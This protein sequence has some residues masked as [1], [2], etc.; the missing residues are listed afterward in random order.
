L[1]VLGISA[2]ALGMSFDDWQPAVNVGSLPGTDPTFNTASLDGCPGPSPNGLR[3]YMASNRPG[4]A[5]GID[6]WISER[7][8]AEDPWGP[9]QNAGA[10]INTAADEFC[11]TPL[12]DNHTLLFVSTRPGGCGGA[13][14]YVAREHDKK[15]WGLPENL[16]C[17]VNSASDEA[18]PFLV[19]ADGTRELYFSSTRAGGFSTEPPGA[20][21]GDS[22]IYAAQVLEDGSVGI[23]AALNAVNTPL[24][25]NR[26]NVRRDGL[27]MFFDSDRPGGLG[28]SDIWTSTRATIA[29]SWLGPVNAG[30]AVNSAATETRPFL[31]WAAGTLYFGSSRPGGNGSS[32]IYVTTRSKT[33]GR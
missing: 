19:D 4:G 17:H 32:D 24:N 5:G 29:A 33:T 1:Y 2:A 26:P 13:D 31:T 21:S 10:P 15:G 8:S 16:G 30:P 22:D 3:F 28:A 11:P 7:E 18:S 9:P 27:E 12:R 20:V 14:I 23:P 6:I 25:D